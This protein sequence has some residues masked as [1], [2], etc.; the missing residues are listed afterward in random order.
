M[1]REMRGEELEAAV[2]A[3]RERLRRLY[4]VRNPCSLADDFDDDP[5]LRMSIER[6]KKVLAMFQEATPDLDI[7]EIR[8]SFQ[9]LFGYAP[10][11]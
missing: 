9:K 3:E 8:E 2:A 10:D 4:P 1:G 11:V 5:P 6:Q 7:K